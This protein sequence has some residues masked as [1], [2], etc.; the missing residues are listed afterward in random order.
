MAVVQPMVSTTLLLAAVFACLHRGLRGEHDRGAWIAFGLGILAW[1]LGDLVRAIFYPVVRPQPSVADV[2]YL[3]FYPGAAIGLVLITRARLRHLTRSLLLDGATALVT[4]AGVAV[5]FVIPEVLSSV[6]ERARDTALVNLAYPVGDTVLLAFLASVIAVTGLRRLGRITVALVMFAF[7]DVAYTIAL[8]EYGQTILWIGAFWVL[9]MLLL[10]T[11]ARDDS[12]P[13]DAHQRAD[14]TLFLVP[15]LAAPVNLAVLVAD[16]PP[17]LAILPASGILLGMVRTGVTFRHTLTLL[18]SRRQAVTDELTGLANRRRFNQH[19]ATAFAADE[20]FGLLVIDL[21]R[22]KAL[23]DGLGHHVG[24]RLLVDFGR[25]LTAALP[26]ARLVA[27]IGGDEF[28]VLTD[29]G[30]EAAAARIEAALSEPFVLDGLELHMGASLG[31]ALAPEHAATP[32]E[33]LQ[34]ADSAMYDAKRANLGFRLYRPNGEGPSRDR[35]ALGEEL[36]RGIAAGELEVHYQP[37]TDIARRRMVGV[38]ALVRWRH[39]ER[40]LLFPD[41]FISL[42]EDLGIVRDLTRHVLQT[43]VDQA[44]TWRASGHDLSVAVNLALA[45]LLDPELPAVVDAALARSGLPAH[46]LV[47]EITEDVAMTDEDHIVAVLARL[48]DRGVELALDDFGTG[49][50]SL[51]RLRRLPVQE[52]KIDRSFVM[53]IDAGDEDASIVRMTIELGHALGIRVVAEGVETEAAL[54]LLASQ[55]CDTAQ[56]FHFSRPVPATELTG[57]LEVGVAGLAQPE[58]AIVITRDQSSA[59]SASSGMRN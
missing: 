32:V 12:P 48:R 59:A 3:S 39:P 54:D 7:A 50:S 19:L 45:D 11:G 37:Q 44:A 40:G 20:P 52:L 6:S 38:E 26:D 27:R 24:D 9:G 15:L 36:R 17:V 2:L 43:A 55:R 29:G 58:S 35:L 51:A 14:W 56:G 10:A 33:L 4:V 46:R 13:P 21:N 53:G 57:L 34:R 30:I 16:V 28:A 8:P 18:E 41:T 23:N 42:A 49:L 22:F 5:A 25:R 47:L 31:G 1:T